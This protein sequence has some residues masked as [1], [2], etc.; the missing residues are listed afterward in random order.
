MKFSK[1]PVEYNQAPP[2]LGEH[3]TEILGILLGL[4][5]QERQQLAKE[6]IIDASSLSDYQ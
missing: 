1:S 6:G 2:I 5:E 4:S 3:N